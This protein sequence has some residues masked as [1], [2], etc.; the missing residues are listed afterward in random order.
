[1]TDAIHS[2]LEEVERGHG[3]RVLYACE[4]GSR[5]WGFASPDSDYDIRFIYAHEAEWY[6]TIEPGRDVIEETS[7]D[8]DVSGWD[9]RKALFLLRS[10]NPLLHEWLGSPIVYRQSQPF[11]E[12]VR[13]LATE[14]WSEKS[15]FGHYLSMARTNY[16]GYLQGETVRTKKYLYVLRPLL[17]CRWLEERHAPPP[18]P[19]AELLG[20]LSL[21][22]ELEQAIEKLLA[23]KAAGSEM[24]EEPADPVLARFIGEEL[25]RLESLPMPAGAVPSAAPFDR[26]L[27]DTVAGRMQR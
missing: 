16:R 10:S 3:V 23:R 8:F 14:T 18:V 9:L 7:G 12:Q 6:V 17:A 19:F 22:S 13:K 24:G 2:L 4:S 26:L 15:S 1:M 20:S 27:Q 25:A 11:T 5:A 21:D